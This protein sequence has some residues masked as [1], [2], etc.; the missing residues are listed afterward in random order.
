[1]QDTAPAGWP[2]GPAQQ[3]SMGGGKMAAAAAGLGAHNLAAAA[4]GA[5]DSQTQGDS[6]LLPPLD[7]DL[8]QQ[9]PGAA[10]ATAAAGAGAGAEDA[11]VL[12]LEDAEKVEE[13]LQGVMR[14]TRLL[15]Q[16]GRQVA[17]VWINLLT[18]EQHA[19]AMLAA[20]PWLTDVGAVCRHIM[21]RQ[22]HNAPKDGSK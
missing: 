9:P 13:L 4:A 12:S 5:T 21:Q 22:Q 2:F 3:H 15:K 17:V 11:G 8:Q 18:A 1:M 14:I 16:H 10:S 6:L 19:D 20:W 7:A